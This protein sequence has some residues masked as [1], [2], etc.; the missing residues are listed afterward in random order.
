MYITADTIDHASLALL[1]Q[2]GAVRAAAV[3]GHGG[4]WGV[5]VK[6]GNTERAL[7]ARRGAVRTFRKFETLVCYLKQIGISQYH[8]NAADFD[9]Q[10]IKASRARPD[11]SERMRSAFEAK[12][13]TDWVREKV[14]ET[15]S[16]PRPNIGHR[17]VMDEV[18]ALIESKRKQHASKATA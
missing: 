14:A 4:G 16:D 8:V 18:Q 10:A 7:A 1:A 13:H 15:L 9:P 11:A 6:C 17:H 12:A 3:I 2:A 5:I